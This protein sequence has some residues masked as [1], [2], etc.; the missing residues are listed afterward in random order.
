M[1]DHCVRDQEEWQKAVEEARAEHRRQEALEAL[2]L[3]V[4][5]EINRHDDW[6]N[7]HHRPENVRYCDTIDRLQR[8]FDAVKGE[9]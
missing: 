1:T 6:R 8:A 5:N 9:Q 3:A 7:D 4:Q 2:V